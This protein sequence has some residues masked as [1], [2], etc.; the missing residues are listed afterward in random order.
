[1]TG[2]FSANVGANGVGQLLTIARIGDP[3]P[4]GGTFNGFGAVTVDKNLVLFVGITGNPVAGIPNGIYGSYSGGDPFVVLRI[5][6]FLDGKEIV[7]IGLSSH[8]HVSPFV[9]LLSG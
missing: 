2:V 6:D 8:G 9:A 5:G 1:M 3:A 4:G 7:G